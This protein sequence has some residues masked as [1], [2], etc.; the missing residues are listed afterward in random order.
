M[1]SA[2]STL[3]GIVIGAA[4]TWLN[5]ALNNRTQWK[6][7]NRRRHA[8]RCAELYQDMRYEQDR[9]VRDE[10]L[11]HDEGRGT[12]PP[13]PRFP[14]EAWADRTAR[15]KARVD[16]HA[17]PAVR[18]LFAKWL[19][20]FEQGSKVGP[21][22]FGSWDRDIDAASSALLEQMRKELEE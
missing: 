19:D 3:L 16:L 21:E 12:R 9:M 15:Q 1:T 13:E 4:L 10:R 6:R 14:D 2:E 18:S 22:S 5:T 20:V 7:E 8:E 17:S 11:I